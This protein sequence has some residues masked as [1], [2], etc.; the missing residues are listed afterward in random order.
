MRILI[1]G[2]EGTIGKILQWELRSRGHEVFCCDLAH[3]S[4]ERY[5]RADVAE[6]R[7]IV[8]A[9][10]FARPEIVFHLAAEFGRANGQAHYER[11][12]RSNVIG[13]Q[14]VIR[15]C[16]F[17]S[18]VL[19]FASSSEAY[20]C[21]DLYAP[22]RE[23]FKEEWLDRFAPEFHNQYALSKW[24]NER[25]IFMA[26]KN[27]KLKAIVLR[28][29]NIYGPGEHYTPYRSVVC[30]FLYRLMKDLPI[31]VYESSFRSHLYVQ[32]WAEWVAQLTDP[33]ILSAIKRKVAPWPGSGTSGVPV[34]NLGGSEYESS[35]A[36]KDRI[37]DMLGGSRSEIT[38]KREES[39]NI[40]SK[41]PDTSQARHWLEYVPKTLLD[42]GLALTIKW[43]RE[44]Y[45]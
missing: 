32:D 26:A 37:L 1:T 39:A 16:L 5:I 20:G 8:W 42:E 38:V 4:D 29:F 34:F 45:P 3:S 21:A 44:T 15:Q 22:E 6:H 25:Q 41:M 17:N 40:I 10:T 30:L 18:S 2:S 14:N 33:R 43:M 9:F 7:E 19:V 13:T 23:N 35:I 24:T 11:M 36:L 27:D 12:W 31:T 28:L